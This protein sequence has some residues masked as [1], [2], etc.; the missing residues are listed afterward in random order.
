MRSS[1][2]ILR[3]FLPVLLAIVGD[4][5]R[6]AGQQPSPPRS[7]TTKPSRPSV[8][9]HAEISEGDVLRINTTLVTVPVSVLDQKNRYLADLHQEQFHVFENGVEQ[10]LAYFASVDKPFMVA[11]LLDIS[12]STQEQLR[13]I[14]DA[15][16][17]F[18]DS[19]RP[20]DQ[21][22]V[23]AFDSRVRLLAQPQMNR[24]A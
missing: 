23:V 11:L 16:I 21:V 13:L 3:C 6:V 24:Q 20:G 9:P 2:K 18:I 17:A 8:P 12:D 5:I 14:Q 1:Q 22:F 15:A 10:K 7:E 4:D 19:L